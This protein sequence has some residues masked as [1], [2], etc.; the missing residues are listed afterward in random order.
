MISKNN[1]FL[2]KINYILWQAICLLTS[3]FFFIFILLNRSPNFLRPLSMSLRTGFGII[4]P[5]TAFVVYFAFRIPGRS[6]EIISLSLTMSLFAFPLAGLWASGQTQSTV[7]SGI[8]PFFDAESYYIDAL[9]L[10]NGSKFS[11]FSARR[12]LF[13]GFLAVLLSLTNHNLMA[14]L[15]ILTAV[16]GFSCYLMARE[17]QRTHGAEGAVFTLMIL[18]LFYR[19]HSGI[20]MTENLGV[21]LG[22]LGFTLLWQGTSKKNMVYIWVGLLITTLALNARAGAFF[23]L[24]ILIIWFSWALRDYSRFSWRVAIITTSAVILGFVLNL[25][26][27]KIIAASSGVPFANFSY[28]LFGLASG[29]KSWAYVFQAHPEVLKLQEPEQSRTIYHLAFEAIKKNPLLTIQGAFFNWK[30]LFSDS[31]YNMYAY[32]GGENWRVNNIARLLMYFLCICGIFYGY[33]NRKDLLSSLAMA[34]VL[35]VLISVP[36]LPPTDAY[37]MRPYAA[38]IIIFAILPSLGVAFLAKQSKLKFFNQAVVSTNSSAPL[39]YSL[40]LSPVILL[41]P[42]FVYFHAIPNTLSTISCSINTEK[43]LIRLDTGNY[44]NIKKQNEAFL[45]WM[46]NFHIGTFKENAHSL[47]NNKMIGWA[48]SIEPGTKIFLTLDFS[49]NQKVLVVL[50]AKIPDSLNGFTQL[51]GTFEKDPSLASLKIFNATEVIPLSP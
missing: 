16:T 1:I 28:T 21:A 35:G 39:L 30:M 45:D 37:R 33:K 15:A 20:S 36:F 26:A 38:S 9:R 12:P 47:P 43:V 22:T 29:G 41:G 2:D 7:L 51:C 17:F 3:S 14:S 18:F 48:D 46:P 34:A 31:W 10:I 6:G 44:V 50:K 11:I 49:S 25:G 19:A 24:P 13:P 32:V 40:F 23:I 4:I 5:I 27:T 8:I 42:L